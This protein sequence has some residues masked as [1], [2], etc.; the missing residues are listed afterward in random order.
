MTGYSAAIHDV[1]RS[2][3]SQPTAV[4]ETESSSVAVAGDSESSASA[5]TEDGAVHR[6]DV[7]IAMAVDRC[8]EDYPSDV[9][10]LAH[11]ASDGS[12]NFVEVDDEVDEDEEEGAGLL[13]DL[14]PNLTFSEEYNS[15]G[16]NSRSMDNV[17]GD[18]TRE[19]I[20]G[21][22]V[23]EQVSSE[24]DFMRDAGDSSSD[25]NDDAHL[26]ESLH[27]PSPEIVELPNATAAASTSVFDRLRRYDSYVP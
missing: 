14:I 16:Q 9:Y 12:S 24:N 11:C 15:I 10:D 22:G 4:M 3:S 5:G 18:G 25:H 23:S 6:T 21:G 19:A 2:L 27:D 7:G 1:L 20:G 8:S 13:D 26:F 17:Q